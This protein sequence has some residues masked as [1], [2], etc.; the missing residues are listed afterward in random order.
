MAGTHGRWRLL[1][2]A[3]LALSTTVA[4]VASAQT[5]T[6]ADPNLTPYAPS[7]F[8]E[9]RPVTALDRIGRIPG[10]QFDG[11]SSARGIWLSGAWE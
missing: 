11:G 6:P 3:I 7:Y 10:F 1:G 5:P 4:G 2:A 9:Y 8:T